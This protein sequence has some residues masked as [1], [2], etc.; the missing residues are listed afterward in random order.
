LINKDF[1]C[2][3]GGYLND[4]YSFSFFFRLSLG[5]STIFGFGSNYS[6]IRMK[7]DL[8]NSLET[9]FSSILDG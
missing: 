8:R 5:V 9:R 2:T 4:S 3:L 1:G 7:P 6:S